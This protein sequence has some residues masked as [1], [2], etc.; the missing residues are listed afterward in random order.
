MVRLSL[1]IRKLVIPIL[2]DV[3]S[4]KQNSIQLNILRHDVKHVQLKYKTSENILKRDR[5]IHK[6]LNDYLLVIKWEIGR[7]QHLCC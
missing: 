6:D 7:K 3:W 1:Y 5:K 4:Q 2:E